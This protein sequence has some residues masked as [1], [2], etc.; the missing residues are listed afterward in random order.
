MNAATANRLKKKWCSDHPPQKWSGQFLKPHGSKSKLS[1]DAVRKAA[2]ST[3]TWNPNEE[4][5]QCFGL[6]DVKR[7]GSGS[8]EECM[9]RCCESE[10]CGAWQWNK[11]VR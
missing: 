1:K 2:C 6:G 3:D 8:A 7:D 11:E 4:I 9:R 10:S 5:G